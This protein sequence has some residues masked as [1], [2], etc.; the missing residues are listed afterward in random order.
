MKLGVVTQEDIDWALS[1]QL[2]IP[3][4]RL[5]K[6][7]IDLAAVER[8]PATLARRFN[9][10]PLFLAGDELSIAIADPLNKEAI[11]AVASTSGCQVTVSV[12]FIREIREMQ[13]LFYGRE[14]TPASFGFTSLQFPPGFSTP[15]M[16]T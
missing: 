5:K 11:T 12:A 14:E 8:V 15:S 13:E 4:V 3:Y 9:L 16:P 6:E 2:N 1:N 10:M 7:G